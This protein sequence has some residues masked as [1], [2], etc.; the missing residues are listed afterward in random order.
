M[1]NRAEQ[2]FSLKFDYPVCFTDN[3]F[4]PENPALVETICRLEPDAR[5][6][7]IVFADQGV[8]DCWPELDNRIDEYVSAHSNHLQLVSKLHAVPGGE[9][10]KSRDGLLDEIYQ[11]LH[12][13]GID[14]HSVIICVGGGAVLD[15]VGYAAATTHRGIRLVRLPT[16]VLAQNDAGIGVKNGINKFGVKNF[17]GTFQPP[18][19]VINDYKF[20]STLEGRDRRAGLAEAI[21]VAS[22]RD[23]G[24]F[25]FLEDNREGLAAF[26]REP[27]ECM[28]RRCAELHLLQIT[29]GGDPFE[30]GSARPL[31]YG[32]WSAHK[33]ESLTNYR[34]RHGEAVAI[35][36][37]IDARYAVEAGMLAEDSGARIFNLLSGLGFTLWDPALDQMDDAGRPCMLRGL[38]EFREHLGGELTVTLPVEIGKGVEVHHMDEKKICQAIGWLRKQCGVS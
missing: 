30:Y 34:M 37:M 7:L 9:Q 16:T 14:R 5:H 15:L 11:H 2:S 27:T 1:D 28:I 29:Q 33:L 35:G 25:D 19:A 36:M 10:C 20:L 26:S 3:A 17:V 4:D 8:L 13:F 21:K 18:F 6:K 38:E 31:D 32:H 23:A 22:I 12:G 24:F